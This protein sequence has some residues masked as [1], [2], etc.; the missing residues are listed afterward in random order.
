MSESN[1]LFPH[2]FIHLFF[3][4]PMNQFELTESILTYRKENNSFRKSIQTR[5]DKMQWKFYD[6]PPFT[7]GDPHYGHLLQSTVKDMV[8]RRMTMRGYRVE[9]KR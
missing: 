9:R 3:F 4:L 2:P 6:G 7:S 8:P 5:S 1:P